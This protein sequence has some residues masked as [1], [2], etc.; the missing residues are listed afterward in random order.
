MTKHQEL[1][2]RIVGTM[3][4][5]AVTLSLG[6]AFAPPAHATRVLR[7]EMYRATNISRLD[8]AEQHLKLAA[9]MSNKARR[10]SV[11]MANAGR[12]F[13]TSNVNTYLKGHHWTRWGENVGVTTESI[14]VLERAFMN[15][16]EHRTNIL[17]GTFKHVAVG[18][19]HRG[20]RLW[21]T[22]FFYG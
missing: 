12:L 7:G 11:A 2:R 8:R 18:A 16:P 5:V 6:L 13:H 14:S 21:V 15:S 17:N 10:H 1:G 9:R 20:G 19:I 3:V 22:V 4:T